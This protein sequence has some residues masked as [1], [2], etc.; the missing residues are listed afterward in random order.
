L[1]DHTQ[2]CYGGWV[3]K[4]MKA[5]IWRNCL[6]A[7]RSSE[8]VDQVLAAA[9]HFFPEASSSPRLKAE[10]FGVGGSF[11]Q[12]P[13]QG[14]PSVL[15]AL[16]THPAASSI[17][18]DIAAIEQRASSLVNVDP[19]SALGIASAAS[20]IGGVRGEQYL[21]GF[22][23]GVRSKP[24]ILHE[25]PLSLTFDLLKR[26]PSLLASPEAWQGTVDYQLAVASHISSLNV[27][28]EFARNHQGCS[29]RQCLGFA[30]Q[31]SYAVR[32]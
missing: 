11:S 28:G 13:G 26:L 23:A 21:D 18:R 9:S 10:F 14:E 27:T 7:S 32:K 4:S 20:N 22:A 2:E 24:K 16:V 30:N 5:M 8:S 1:A 25:L 17:P 6:A 15:M 12:V 3:G 31:H 19:E 29:K